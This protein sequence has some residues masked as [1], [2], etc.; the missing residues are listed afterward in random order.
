MEIRAAAYLLF[1]SL[2]LVSRTLGSCASINQQEQGVSQQLH[3][4]NGLRQIKLV[5]TPL[6]MDSC[7]NISVAIIS[8]KTLEIWST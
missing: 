7:L 3:S 4:W 5:A 1:F 6:Q 8:G 2:L